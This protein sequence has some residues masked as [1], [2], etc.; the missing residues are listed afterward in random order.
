[1]ALF[2]VP[3]FLNKRIFFYKLMG[4]GKNGTFDIRPDFQQWA[5]MLFWKAE[6]DMKE[7]EIQKGTRDLFGKFIM[8]W[9]TL[10]NTQCRIF[11]LQPY[12]GHGSWDRETF[13]PQ[14]EKKEDPTGPIA[15]LTRAT[16]RIQRL[17][18]FWRAVPS[19]AQN[20]SENKGFL[21]SIGIGE[22]PFI[23]QATF[24][25]W[26]TAQDMK[27]FAYQ[28]AE[29]RKVIQNTRKENWYAEELF[30]RFHLLGDYPLQKQAQK[31]IN[32]HV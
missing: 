15:V 29:H 9:L 4:S 32:A 24:S 27:N 17:L 28:K 21:Y 18:H 26:Q 6:K 7:Q 10:F 8:A 13:I 22:I 5:V 2:H 31:D 14:K 3:L 23:K 11:H 25:I 12:A 19:T 1:M 30:L 16:I 20:L